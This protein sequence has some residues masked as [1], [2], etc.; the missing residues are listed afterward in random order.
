M[1][2]LQSMC[3]AMSMEQ[4][5]AALLEELEEEIALF[6][7][8]GN[9]DIIYQ[10]NSEGSVSPSSEEN[11]EPVK[12]QQEGYKEIALSPEGIAFFKDDI[13]TLYTEDTLVWPRQNLCDSFLFLLDGSIVNKFI[14]NQHFMRE[15]SST[16]V[17]AKYL[18]H[19]M[20]CTANVRM[21]HTAWNNLLYLLTTCNSM[22][23]MKNELC[24]ALLNL[25][26]DMSHLQED[27]LHYKSE[28]IPPPSCAFP[29]A[30]APQM[31]DSQLQDVLVL[32]LRFLSRWLVSYKNYTAKDVDDLLLIFLLI[33]L[34]PKVIDSNLEP[35]IAACI[36]HTLNLYSSDQE[37]SQRMRNGVEF[38]LEYCDDDLPSILHLCQAYL[39]P[40]GR[41]RKL[42]GVI[43]FHQVCRH[44][45]LFN[46]SFVDDVQVKDIADILTSY[47]Q[48]NPPV[49]NAYDSYYIIKLVDFSLHLDVIQR[50]QMD[51]LKTI[52]DL[53][54]Q[55]FDR[56][57]GGP[58]DLNPTISFQHLATTLSKWKKHYDRLD[59]LDS[60]NPSVPCSP[61]DCS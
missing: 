39:S 50:D 19:L 31:T 9:G 35:H 32:L 54:E 56:S 29:K 11:E 36:T 24:L 45:K 13:F 42:C 8:H 59:G 37:F 1:D 20:C 60:T 58:D 48:V 21:R 30:E 22:P 23:Y 15:I 6:D 18:L 25:G 17:L 57:Q 33:G 61:L 3:H 7:L 16:S 28:I 46:F 26:G 27:M 51:N 12:E 2:L 43:A 40:T 49:S 38:V 14:K 5:E 41:T 44:L 47:F 4:K 34:D 55:K 52:C 10:D 53:A